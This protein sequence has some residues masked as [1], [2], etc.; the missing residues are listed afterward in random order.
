M[1]DVTLFPIGSSGWFL[2]ETL[3]VALLVRSMSCIG[4]KKVC[5]ETLKTKLIGESKTLTPVRKP[6]EAY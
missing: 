1:A 6:E 2:P 5:R 3:A 4:A